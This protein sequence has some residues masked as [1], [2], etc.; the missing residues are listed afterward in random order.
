ME[1]KINATLFLEHL[2]SRNGIL[3]EDYKIAPIVI[4]SWDHNLIRSI[5]EQY[6]LEKLANWPKTSEVY[7]WTIDNQDITFVTLPVGAPSAVSTLEQL[8]AL[9]AKIFIGIGFAGSLN[10]NIQVGSIVIAN[11]CIREE[12]T[13]YHYIKDNSESYPS[14]RLLSQLEKAFRN[15]NVETITGG[16]WTTDAIYRELKSKIRDYGDRDILGVEME[17]SALYVVGK[18]RG[19]EVCNVLAISDELWTEQ[20]NPQFGSEKLKNTVETIRKVLFNNINLFTELIE[21]SDDEEV[22]A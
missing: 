18:F 14:K 12:G 19:I 9:G 7:N 15:D 1:E 22:T 3:I 20:W 13:S 21:S 8:I 10:P 6:K 4:G 5:A 11:N 2:A 17:T 16:I